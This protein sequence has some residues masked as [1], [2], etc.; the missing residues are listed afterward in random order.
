[1]DFTSRVKL[2]K[3]QHLLYETTCK[4]TRYPSVK[5]SRSNI[6]R[7]LCTWSQN[8]TTWIP[9]HA[10]LKRTNSGHLYW[11]WVPYTS[12]S[13]AQWTIYNCSTVNYED[14]L[15]ERKSNYTLT[16]MLST[17]SNYSHVRYWSIILST[18]T[19][20]DCCCFVIQLEAMTVFRTTL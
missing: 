19:S 8:R 5:A 15:T 20:Q 3:T 12:T 7:L 4:A 2:K 1:M 14:N 11:C 17:L 18:E 13:P 9:E 6:Q 16:E 10:N